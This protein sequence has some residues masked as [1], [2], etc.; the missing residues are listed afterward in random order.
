MNKHL[1]QTFDLPDY[2]QPS[3][4]DIQAAMAKAQD[5]EK[6]LKDINGFEAHDEEMDEISKMAV[7]A[8]Q[9]LLELGMNVDTRTAGEILSTSATML[10]IAMD[11]RNSKVDKKLRLIKL[12]MDKMKLDHSLATDKEAPVNGGEIA[13]DRNEILAQIHNATKNR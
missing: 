5:L 8:H 10:K 12:Q 13:M 6:S 2:E 4:D 1:A 9:D 7:S 3:E 11:A